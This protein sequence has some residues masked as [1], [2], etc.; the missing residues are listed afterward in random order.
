MEATLGPWGQAQG[1]SVLPLLRL[2]VAQLHKGSRARSYI[3]FSL[4]RHQ[5]PLLVLRPGNWNYRA[6][7]AVFS[8]VYRNASVSF[9][10]VNLAKQ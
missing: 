5:P 9:C 2:L 4:Y 6:T 10:G 7:A 1:R 3:S 8:N